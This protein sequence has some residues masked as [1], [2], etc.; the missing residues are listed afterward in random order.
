MAQKFLEDDFDE[1]DD[2]DEEQEFDPAAGSRVL[3]KRMRGPRPKKV[4]IL[5]ED[6][7]LL[8]INKPAGVDSTRGQFS[9]DSVLDRL[10]EIR[11]EIGDEL[12]LV[13]R[14]DRETSGVMILAKTILAQRSLTN[15]WMEGNV[16]KTYLALVRGVVEPPTG[17]IDLPLHN[18]GKK[19]EPVIAGQGKAAIT[20]Y[21]RVEQ[22][23]QFA[24]LEVNPRTGRM[25]QVRV[26]LAS[27]GLPIVADQIYGS[28]EPLL[29]SRFKRSYRP[30]K[31]KSQRALIDRLAL[32][33]NQI[34]VVHPATNQEMTFNADLPK[35]FKRTVHQ[36]EKFGR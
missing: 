34:T 19:K 28:G 24:L 33:A 30:S 36:L 11:P 12:R 15:Q 6:E 5:Y 8:V 27:I 23:R 4:E 9:T 7:H 35:D 20:E 2:L 10:S 1:F 17:T 22:Y 25:H 13:H 29:L 18:T 32:H 31:H 16:R 26:H 14:I 21:Q 3:P